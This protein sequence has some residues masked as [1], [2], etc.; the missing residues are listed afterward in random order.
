[1][2]LIKD[3][4]KSTVSCTNILINN[5]VRMKIP[6]KRKVCTAPGSEILPS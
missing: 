2:V 3:K 1:V 4:N 5:F 6:Q